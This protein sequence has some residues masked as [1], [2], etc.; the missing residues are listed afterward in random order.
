[1]NTNMVEADVLDVTFQ[2]KSRV[3]LNFTVKK[4]TL[5]ILSIAILT[6]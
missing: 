3:L 6:Q 2:I 1:M 4:S 5:V